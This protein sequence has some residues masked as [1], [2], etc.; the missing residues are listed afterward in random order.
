MEPIFH[1]FNDNITSFHRAKTAF[2]ILAKNKK[3]RQEMLDASSELAGV[4]AKLETSSDLVA[5]QIPNVP[6]SII[7]EHGPRAADAKW[8]FS[9]RPY[10]RR[11]TN[12]DPTLWDVSARS[13]VSKLA[14]A[15]RPGRRP[16]CGLPS[17]RRV[18]YSYHTQASST[19]RTVQ[20]LFGLPRHSWLLP[21][22]SLLELWI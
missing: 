12:S 18:W 10:D 15:F 11:D 8:V 7:T 4:N 5:L 14:C 9:D 13:T 20:T 19:N 2:A 21:R 22:S 6:V 1:Y 17:L 16:S 3:I